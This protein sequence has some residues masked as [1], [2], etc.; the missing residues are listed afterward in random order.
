MP[1]PLSRRGFLSF[2]AS[3]TVMALL[4]LS[5]TSA[6]AEPR[7]Y[8]GD[9]SFAIDGSDPV[10][11]F[12]LGKHTKGSKAFTHDWEGATWAF[13]TAEHRD[14]FAAN[15]D[16]YAPQFG[17]YC[18]Y[19]AAKNYIAPTVP[20]AWDIVDGKLYLNYSLG[21]QKRWHSDVPGMIAKGN[22][23]WPQLSKDLD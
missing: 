5:P 21:V 1:S 17:G 13:A 10:A 6:M 9:T 18:A 12:L 22:T 4:S 16:Q 14:L 11:Y 19:A 15:P 3:S 8:D 20:E 2:A 7:I 23:N